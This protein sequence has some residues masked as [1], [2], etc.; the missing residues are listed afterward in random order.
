MDFAHLTLGYRLAGRYCVERVIKAG[1]MGAVYEA[2]H[3]GTHR[4]VALKLMHPNIVQQPEARERFAQEARVAARV[5]SRHV[6]DVLD[7]GV[8]DDVG[9]APFLVM[10]LLEGDEL[11]DLLRRRGRLSAADVLV[12]LQQLADGLEA[13]HE[14]GVVHRDIKP[15]NLFLVRRPDDEPGAPPLLKILDF[16]IAK[17]SQGVF[18]ESTASTGTPLYMAPEQLGRAV[19]TPAADIWAFGLVAFALLVGKPFW[20]VDTVA[21]LYGTLLGGEY[22]S[23]VARAAEHGVV[24]PAG[25]DT[26]FRGCVA[27]SASDRFGRVEEAMNALRAA[28]G[29]AASLEAFTSGRTEVQA[30]RA[31]FAGKYDLVRR[32]GAG[33]MGEVHLAVHV[34]LG[35]QVAIKLLHRGALEN[36]AAVE[37]FQREGRAAVALKSPHVARVLDLGVTDSGEPFMVMEYVEGKDLAAHLAAHGPLSVGEAATYVLQACE[38][39]AEAHAKGIVHRDLK[40]ANLYLATAIDGQPLV[41]ILDFGISKLSAEAQQGANVQLTQTR[42]SMGSPSYMS[43]EQLRSAR[44]VDGRADLWSLGVVLHELVTGALPFDAETLTELTARVIADEPAPPSRI[45]SGVSPEFDRIVARCLAKDRERRYPDVATLARDLE[46]LAARL[47][48]AAQG[49]AARIERST[50]RLRGTGGTDVAWGTTDV[51]SPAS[52]PGTSRWALALV[53]AL[54][55]ALSLAVAVPIR[56]AVVKAR[57]ASGSPH[58]AP[59]AAGPTPSAVA[60]PDDRTHLPVLAE[61]GAPPAVVSAPPVPTASAAPTALPTSRGPQAAPLPKPPKPPPAAPAPSAAPVRPKVDPNAMPDER[62]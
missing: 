44:S 38:G 27:K 58:P 56:A 8:A 60:L 20:R 3:L 2:T 17:L 28:L 18:H 10:E 29:G 47:P 25:F 9:A 21:E 54:A 12:C 22:P 42:T 15:E 5:K 43:P 31:L 35:H 57:A 61:A 23:A 53:L 16:G 11:G 59:S 14:A 19:I 50:S 55:L 30:P 48:Q 7:A 6:V 62:R 49:V 32:L 4:R 24:L 52:P 26:F 39:L 34:G 13:A 45:A 40:P 36:P 41:K 51:S 1:G 37:R 46:P 33:G